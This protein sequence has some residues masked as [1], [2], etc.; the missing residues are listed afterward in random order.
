MHQRMVCRME[1]FGRMP[2]LR[3]VAAAHMTASQT[4]PQLDPRIAHL[5]TFFAAIRAGYYVVDLIDM[6][7]LYLAKVIQ[8]F[9]SIYRLV[10][11]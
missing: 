1:M 6:L 10:S 3:V 7:A 11:G 5:Q 2:I 9:C 4:Q 8:Q